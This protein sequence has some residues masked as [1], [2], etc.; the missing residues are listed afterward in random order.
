MGKLGNIIGVVK[1]ENMETTHTD[2]QKSCISFNLD[3]SEATDEYIIGLC[4]GKEKVNIQGGAS[5][6]WPANLYQDKMDG[7]T[8]KAGFKIESSPTK[9]LTDLVKAIIKANPELTEE[10]ATKKALAI[11]G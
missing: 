1:I 8:I 3:F 10:Q 9:A 7:Q 4:V 5:R 11:I 2:G 6:D